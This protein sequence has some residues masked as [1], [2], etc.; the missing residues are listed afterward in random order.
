MLGRSAGPI[1]EKSGLVYEFV[2][3]W[4]HAAWLPAAFERQLAPPRA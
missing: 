3:E 1:S 4:E 2:I